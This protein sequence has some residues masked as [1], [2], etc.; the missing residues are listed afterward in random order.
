MFKSFQKHSKYT[1]LCHIIQN[2]KWLDEHTVLSCISNSLK[3]TSPFNSK[4]NSYYFTFAVISF[5]HPITPHPMWFC[6]V[7]F[8][9]H[10]FRVKKIDVCW[11]E[12][13]NTH[14]QLLSQ[15]QWKLAVTATQ[16]MCQCLMTINITMLSNG[17]VLS[18]SKFI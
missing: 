4:I 16:T 18:A 1:G 11:K 15:P 10:A 13:L 5:L 8:W 9:L 12:N 17:V 6:P 14:R 2:V 7:Q 3:I